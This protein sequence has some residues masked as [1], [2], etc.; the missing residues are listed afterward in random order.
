MESNT[1][2]D[3]SDSD[4]M[5]EGKTKEQLQFKKNYRENYSSIIQACD[6]GLGATAE[7]TAC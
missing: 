6:I 2:E 4:Y 7:C 5:W 3:D 1:Y